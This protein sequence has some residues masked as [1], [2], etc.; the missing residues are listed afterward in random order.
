[1][2]KLEGIL[3]RYHCWKECNI[4]WVSAEK[5]SRLSIDCNQELDIIFVRSQHWIG[6]N[7]ERLLVEKFTKLYTYIEIQNRTKYIGSIY[8]WNW[9]TFSHEHQ[10]RKGENIRQFSI[11]NWTVYWTYFRTELDLKF[12]IRISNRRLD[13][14]TVGCRFLKIFLNNIHFR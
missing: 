9:R 7:N 14:L 1:M 5:W 3:D 12:R 6:G 10:L 11:C 8:E 4:G 2:S 13:Y